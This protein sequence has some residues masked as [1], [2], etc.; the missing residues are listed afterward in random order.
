MIRKH[1]SL[2]QAIIEDITFGLVRM[3]VTPYRF[4]WTLFINEDLCLNFC[5]IQPL[6]TELAVVVCPILSWENGVSIFPLLFLIPY[7]SYLKVIR[8][9][10][11]ACMSSISGQI[12][13]LTTG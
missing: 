2:L 10:I 3:N 7:I 13:P 5:Q 1:F 4:S 11:R 12:V 6:T 8:T 9:S